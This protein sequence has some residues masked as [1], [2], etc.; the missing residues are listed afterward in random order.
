MFY[1]LLPGKGRIEAETGDHWCATLA[2][3]WAKA[4]RN[5]QNQPLSRFTFSVDAADGTGPAIDMTGLKGTLR[6]RC[7]FYLVLG[8]N[9][10]PPTD[11]S[12]PSIFTTV[13]E[14][15]GV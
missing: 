3:K 1:A 15:L 4:E 13:Q 9:G 6:L 11:T 10:N 8:F 5:S 12:A 7:Q 2:G 14:D